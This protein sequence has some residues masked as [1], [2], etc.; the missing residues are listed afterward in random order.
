[1]L[2]LCSFIILS[3]Q[4]FCNSF[5]H[6]ALTLSV[7]PTTLLLSFAYFGTPSDATTGLPLP[8]MYLCVQLNS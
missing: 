1:M 5:N 6:T 7:T 3:G 4:M 2:H 8:R